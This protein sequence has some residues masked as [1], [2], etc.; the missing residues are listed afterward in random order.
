MLKYFDTNIFIYS[1]LNQGIE[2]QESST[3][4]IENA[5]LNN[6]MVISILVLQEMVYALSKNK[7]DRSIIKE[8]YD[9]LKSFAMKNITN[10]VF[11]EAIL[12]S[13]ETNYFQNIN[14]CIHIKFAEKH[15]DKLYTFDTDFEKFRSHTKLEIEILK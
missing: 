7:I 6:E 13:F 12:L 9:K 4:I 2:K 5:I 3:N 15:C 1:F 8:Y 10:D 14:D 11:E